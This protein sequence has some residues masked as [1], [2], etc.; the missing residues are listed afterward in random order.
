MS[1]KIQSDFFELKK[2]SLCI[3]ELFDKVSKHTSKQKLCY[4]PA[5]MP[6]CA[7]I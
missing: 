7:V 2:Y 1:V 4:P 6:N 5:Y 3:A